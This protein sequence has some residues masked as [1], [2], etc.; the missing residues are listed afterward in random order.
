[1]DINE[2][3]IKSFQ[4]ITKNKEVFKHNN[5]SFLIP[6]FYKCTYCDGTYHEVRKITEII[7]F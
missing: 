5:P 2:K 1:M 4:D 3:I 6:Q 7:N